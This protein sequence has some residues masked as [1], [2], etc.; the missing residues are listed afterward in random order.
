MRNTGSSPL[1][2]ISVFFVTLTMDEDDTILSH[3]VEWVRA[4]ASQTE[5]VYVFA[6]HVGNV[7]NM[8][9]NILVKEIGG[10]NFI[11]R[12][13]GLKRIMSGYLASIFRDEETI[14]FYHMCTWP[15]MLLGPINR[16][17]GKRQCLWYSHQKSD[18]FL[19]IGWKNC[20]L[21]F[22]PT[23]NTFPFHHTKKVRAV[24]HGIEASQIA[25]PNLRNIE[26][27]IDSIYCIGRIAPI[28]NLEP[29]F[30]AVSSLKSDL[31]PYPEIVLIG[32]KQDEEYF[33]K[34]HKFAVEKGIN[35]EWKD[36]IP[37]QELKSRLHKFVLTCN[38]TKGSIDKSALEAAMAGCYI[39]SEN[40]DLIQLSGMHQIWQEVN[41]GQLPSLSEQVEII[42]NFPPSISDKF[43]KKISLFSRSSNALEVLIETILFQMR[44]IE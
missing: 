27:C 34:L 42:R 14:Y 29:I 33:L 20:D 30:T 32:P 38:G 31:R 5:Y 28:K 37:R 35:F 10:G 16:I 15:L 17:L 11:R 1:K 12:L 13:V 21:I 25:L 4:L 26:P 8:P 39:V 18:L 7:N 3:T 22:T 41:G 6:T 19:K 44:C 36:A 2:K 9:E 43:R 24:G 23:K 40:L